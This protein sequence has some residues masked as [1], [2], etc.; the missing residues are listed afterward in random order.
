M[1]SIIPLNIYL[2]QKSD[3]NNSLNSWTNYVIHISFIAAFFSLADKQIL[4]YA[5]RK[6]GKKSIK[7]NV[8][9]NDFLW[10]NFS[11]VLA[12]EELWSDIQEHSVMSHEEYQIHF[13]FVLMGLVMI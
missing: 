10:I 2:N 3:F 11:F 9:I 7:W 5:E 4:L 13:S 1:M 6:K 12:Y 8:K